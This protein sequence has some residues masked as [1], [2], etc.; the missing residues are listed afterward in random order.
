MIVFSGPTVGP[1]RT[2]MEWSRLRNP[3]QEPIW[4]VQYENPQRVAVKPAEL[5]K[6]KQVNLTDLANITIEVLCRLQQL[7]SNNNTQN[8]W[9][10]FLIS[11]CHFCFSFVTIFGKSN[12]FGS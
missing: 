5:T 6:Q 7:Y 2:D 3:L 9:V 10:I 11:F 1:I 12:R 4:I 8:E